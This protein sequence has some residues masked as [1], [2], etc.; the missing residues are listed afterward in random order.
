MDYQSELIALAQRYGVVGKLVF[1]PT[2]DHDDLIRTMGQF[3]V[4]LALE[5]PEQGNYS[6]TV[7]NK[8]F[9][10]LLA[11]LAVAATDTP[12]QREVLEQI[13]SGGFLYPAGNAQ[14]LADGLRR[15]MNCP[16]SLRAAQQAAWNVA[17]EKFCWDREKEKFLH[18]FQTNS[19]K[20]VVRTVW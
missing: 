14:A 6:R 12:G 13:P 5:R 19:D 1:H 20:Q 7:T 18:I 8:V 2:V 16:E 10:Y 11:G 15:W 9:S 3:D 17:R 4:G